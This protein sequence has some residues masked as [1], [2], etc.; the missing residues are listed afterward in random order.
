MRPPSRQEVYRL[1]GLDSSGHGPLWYEV[2]DKALLIQQFKNYRWLEG[3][4]P[5]SNPIGGRSEAVA[6]L[7]APRRKTEINRVEEPIRFLQRIRDVYQPFRE[8]AVM[9]K[10]L[11][12]V[13]ETPMQMC[14]SAMKAGPPKRDPNFNVE[15]PPWKAV[16]DRA[17]LDKAKLKEQEKRRRQKKRLRR[18]LQIKPRT[19]GQP[20][21]KILHGIILTDEED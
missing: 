3:N 13:A 14:D 21:V 2:N 17:K 6:E 12:G 18:N 7:R 4:R 5:L 8:S 19:A 20:T 9:E 11:T 16:S 15:F 1:I 10:P